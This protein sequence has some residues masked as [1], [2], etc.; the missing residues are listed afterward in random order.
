MEIL[1]YLGATAPPSNMNSNIHFQRKSQNTLSE[2]G[3]PVAMEGN[4]APLYLE[5]HSRLI[6][7][8]P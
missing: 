6:I 4:E 1:A 7:L 8:T 2:T 5:L 3:F